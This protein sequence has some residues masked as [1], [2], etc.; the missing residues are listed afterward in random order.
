MAPVGQQALIDRARDLV[1]GR[2]LVDEALAGGIE[3]AG[4]LAADRFGDQEAVGP[5]GPDD[6]GGMELHELQ[7]GQVGSGVVPE[8]QAAAG[9]AD[10]IRRARPQRGRAAGGQHRGGGVDLRSVGQPHPGG[11]PVGGDDLHR[12]P[13]LQHRDPLILGDER[14][15]LADD[16]P[17]GGRPAGVHDAPG[18]VTSLQTEREMPVAV[19]VEADAE[20]RPGPRRR[21]EPLCTARVPLTRAPFLAPRSGC[22]RGAARGCRRWPGQ[23]PVRPAPSSWRTRPGEWPRRA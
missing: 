6:G 1:T 4:A 20:R 11:T 19:G 3:Q 23:R 8:E 14:R 13:L 10:R 16:P 12:P 7:V 9:G 21:P 5:V 22:P 18:R 2:E 15:E 17:A